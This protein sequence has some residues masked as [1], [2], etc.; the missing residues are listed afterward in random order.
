V[1]LKLDTKT[2]AALALAKGRP[3]EFAWD[4]E[5]EGF[6]LRL[7][8]RRDGGLLRTWAAQYRANGHTRRI[9]L[10]SADKVTVAKAREAARK[11]LARVELGHDPQREKQA[12]RAASVHTFR[13]VADAYLAAKESGLRPASLRITKLYLTGD[14]FRPLHAMG[15]AEIT[16]ADIAARLSAITRAHSAHTAAAARRAISALFRW[17][18]EE[19]WTQTNPVIGTR[20]PQEAA[21]RDR[22]LSDAELAA[23]WR[24][25]GDDD[26]GKILRLLILLGSRRQEIGGMRW[27]EFDDLDAGIWTLPKERSKNHR[28]HTITL[29][30]VALDIIRSVSHG[31]RD[32]LF[33][34]RGGGGFNGWSN[35]KAELDQRLADAVKPWRLHDIRR[36]VATRM[37]DIGIEPHH[38]E[39][40]LNHFSGHRRG[41]AGVYN[42]SPYERQVKA[43]LIA[44]SRY[45]LDL[46]EGHASDNVVALHA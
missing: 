24:A 41:V 17:T 18:M 11:L 6:G 27:S 7:R 2:V 31:E 45:V 15:V 23:I 20:R 29:P 32:H 38:V 42:R 8:R 36:T 21:A 46:V 33:G 4:A 44:W 39:A 16:H 5:L 9:T 28:A 3:E 37:A 40:A 10:G 19:G 43:A 34:E 1:K 26:F 14:Y 30:P 22:V 12:K 35:A 25:C 13:A